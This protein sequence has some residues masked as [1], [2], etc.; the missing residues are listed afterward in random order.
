M[1][2]Y[3]ALILWYLIID[4]AIT[5]KR[6]MPA[7]IRARINIESIFLFLLLAGILFLGT[8][9]RFYDLGG[10]SLWSDEA[11]T[12]LRSRSP[13]AIITRWQLAPLYSMTYFFSFL[14]TNDFI[15]RLPHALMGILSIALIYKVG[16]AFFGRDEALISAF[17]LAIAPLHIYHS[18][19]ARYY[20]L[21]V[22]LSL[23]ALL[24]LRKG[25]DQNKPK[26]YVAFILTSILNIYNHAFA[27]IIVGAQV[28]Y[29]Y[30]SWR[31]TI[32]QKSL[33]TF[34][35]FKTILPSKAL[36]LIGVGFI[37]IVLNPKIWGH[38]IFK[39]HSNRMFNLELNA[40]FFYTLLSRF[41]A[42]SG[43]P[44]YVYL[45][46][47]GLGLIATW[48]FRR[49][50]FVLLIT[51]FSFTLA[52]L[53]FLILVGPDHL[54]YFRY[55][56]FLLPFYLLAVASGLGLISRGIFFLLGQITG[57]KEQKTRKAWATGLSVA[58]TIA[59]FIPLTQTA[60]QTYYLD[61]IANYRTA[62]N[63]LAQHVLPGDAIA[64]PPFNADHKKG[65]RWYYEQ[66]K[67]LKGR[68]ALVGVDSFD[69]LDLLL[70]EHQCVWFID[71]DPLAYGYQSDISGIK[72]RITK[73][74]TEIKRLPNAVD[75]SKPEVKDELIIYSSC[76]NLTSYSEH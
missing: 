23:L 1:Q 42:R 22:L 39:D 69:K 60:I 11:L 49:E 28:T 44:F 61:Q 72:N 33:R 57:I 51:I 32:S 46:L 21:M 59:V 53:Q 31:W 26:W 30:L 14:G 8:T 20:A 6:T 35:N 10:D 65:L 48:I 73:N 70:N 27:F 29:A 15:I 56:T 45:V 64:V 74:F 67:D 75:G 43:L 3:F 18:R 52:M 41:G 12:A 55:M 66:N 9:L 17:L 34:F 7:N 71:I 54:F 24:F 50:A 38:I 5:Q 4:E 2:D 19:N 76:L 63:F 13:R 16:R 25:L 68:S 37:V 62:V 47:F 40:D 36:L 58:L